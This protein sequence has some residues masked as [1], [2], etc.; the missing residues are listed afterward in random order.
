LGCY[1]TIPATDPKVFSAG[2][3]DLLTMYPAAVVEMAADPAR[4]IPAFVPYPSL[5][6]FRER[7][8]RILDEHNH[9]LRL[10]QYRLERQNRR[11]LPEPPQPDEREKAYIIGGFRDLIRRL[12]S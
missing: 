10:E 7:L 4:G 6:K 5:A 1:D 8:E 12:G 9:D 3:V 11:Q 2:L